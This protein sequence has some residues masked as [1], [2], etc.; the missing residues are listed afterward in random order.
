MWASLALASVGLLSTVAVD[1]ARAGSS[2]VYDMDA[3]LN[4][5]YPLSPGPWSNA[6]AART[7]PAAVPHRAPRPVA[8]SAPQDPAPAAGLA[9]GWYVAGAVGASVAPDAAYLGD[10]DLEASYSVGPLVAGSG[11]YAWP[12]GFRVE[13]QI[14]WQTFAVAGFQVT[15]AGSIAG[16]TGADLDGDGDVTGLSLLAN[17]AYDF[18]TGTAFTPYVIAGAGVTYATFS[19]IKGDGVTIVDDS[20]WVLTFNVG[21]G[22]TYAITRSLAAEV[23][24][25]FITALDPQLRDAAGNTFDAEFQAH[26]VFAGVRYT[27]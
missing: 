25:R 24:Y 3:L 17:A 14:L 19:D 7:E 8:A 23:G 12:S 6:G 15:S 2:R 9:S 1:A 10:I 11:G 22:V 26:N 27:F 21:I 4:E 16:I 5:P 20:D 18:D 13:G